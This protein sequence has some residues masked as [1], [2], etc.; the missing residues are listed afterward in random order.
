MKK[1]FWFF[2]I[3]ISFLLFIVML[4]FIFD[5]DY[6]IRGLQVV[7]FKGHTTAYIHD[8]TE[9][10]N[11]KIKAG[12]E[13]QPWPLHNNYNSMPPTGKLQEINNELGTIAFLIIKNDSI[14]YENYTE[15]YDEN[16]LTNSFSMAKSITTALLGK[17]IRDGFIKNLDQPVSHF[18]P[19]IRSSFDTPLTVGDLSSMSS[20]LNWDEDYYNPFSLTARAYFDEDLREVVSNLRITEEPGREFN[21]LSGNTLMLGMVLEK[22]TGSNLSSYLSQSF[23]IPMGMKNDALWQLDSRESGLEKAYCCIASNAKDFARFGKLFKDYGKWNGEQILDSS[24]VATAT[25][26]RFDDSPQYGY[27]LWLSDHKDKDIFYLRGVL[28]QY[29]I[30]I[31]EDDLIIVRLGH[32]LRKREKDEDHSPDFYI[33][34]D[35]AYKMLSYAE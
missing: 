3:L 9:F 5:Y 15:G 1:V 7:Y 13:H 26:P 28:G 25:K 21:Y 12:D 2:A 33:Y 29:V 8:H 24:F 10:D 11:R 31:P 16:S 23:W 34:I 4:L 27:G 6:I 18:L 22:A 14:L 35:E 20:G 30:V 32:S 17:A 19:E